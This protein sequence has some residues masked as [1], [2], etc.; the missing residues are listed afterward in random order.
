MP[1]DNDL[2]IL[3]VD[4]HNIFLPNSSCNVANQD[5]IINTITN[6]SKTYNFTIVSE[7]KNE[8]ELFLTAQPDLYKRY[9]AFYVQLLPCPIGFTLKMESVIVILFFQPS[10]INV[11][12]IILLSDVLRTPG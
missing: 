6:S 4:T 3:F 9:D 12:L 10:L 5:Q 11:M 7:S 1:Y 8:C 2:S